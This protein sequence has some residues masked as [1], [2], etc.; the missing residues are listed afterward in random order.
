MRAHLGHGNPRRL[1]DVCSLS[2][3]REFRTTPW[4]F[5]RTIG[6]KSVSRKRDEDGPLERSWKP[7]GVYHLSRLSIDRVGTGDHPDG[8]LKVKARRDL[9]FFFFFLFLL[10]F[11][12]GL[13]FFLLGLVH[14]SSFQ[15]ISISNALSSFFFREIRFV[16]LL[17]FHRICVQKYRIQIYL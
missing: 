9:S 7:S 12:F 2:M 11:F 5:P 1:R 14:F 10:F 3:W 16:R 17:K 6:L 13:C 15:T 4:Y 8:E